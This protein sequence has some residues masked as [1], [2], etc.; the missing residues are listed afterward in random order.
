MLGEG[1][2]GAAPR[3]VGL[4]TRL[5]RVSRGRVARCGAETDALRGPASASRPPW[6]RTAAPGARTQ[7]SLRASTGAER[8]L[9]RANAAVDVLVVDDDEGVRQTVAEILRRAKH[10]VA[11]AGDGEQALHRLGELDVRVLVVDVRMPRLDGLA[12]L[13]L[14]DDPPPSI[15]ISA[16]FVEDDVRRA[17]GSKVRAYLRKP[18]RPEILLQAVSA[19]LGGGSPA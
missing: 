4:R 8:G 13:R 18:F 5:R 12:L 9:E 19:A 1:A 6:R 11:E 7:T 2:D 17:L 16:Y 10:T 15:V 3:A 14:L